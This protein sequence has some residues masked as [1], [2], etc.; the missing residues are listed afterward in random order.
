MTRSTDSNTPA[1]TV[2]TYVNAISEKD[3]ER[4]FDFMSERS[5]PSGSSAEASCSMF[6]D[7]LNFEVSDFELLEE[8][9]DGDTATVTFQAEMKL[10]GQSMPD[11]DTLSLIREDGSWKVDI[12][13]PE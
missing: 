9:I 1:G 8:E 2:E 3:C 4:M 10:G 5:V 11:Q 12:P 6:M 13:Y 7:V